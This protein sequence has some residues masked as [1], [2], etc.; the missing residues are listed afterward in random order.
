MGDILK[1][2]KVKNSDYQR[3]LHLKGELQQSKAVNVS[4]HEVIAYLLDKNEGVK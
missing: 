1:T 4:L 3:I 2:L